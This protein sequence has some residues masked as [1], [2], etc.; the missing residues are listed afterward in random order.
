M[1]EKE[2]KET[3]LNVFKEGRIDMNFAVYLLDR[4][5][6]TYS[7]NHNIASS[8]NSVSKSL[9]Y[10]FELLW[11]GKVTSA[12]AIT[13]LKHNNIPLDNNRIYL[14]ESLAKKKINY[15]ECNAFFYLV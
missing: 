9:E 4:L 13:F 7:Y 6:L 10:I 14:I 12:H 5:Y 1:N 2:F 3:I 8:Q 11:E 15:V